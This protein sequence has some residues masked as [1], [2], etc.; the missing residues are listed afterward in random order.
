M[1]IGIITYWFN[2]GQA[3]V[4]RFLRSSLE[5]L[6]YE[7]FVFVR[8]DASAGLTSTQDVWAQSNLHT[9][10][11]FHPKPQEYL[12]WSEDHE[13]D[14]VF[15]FQNYSFTDIAELKNNGITTIGCFMRENIGSNHVADINKAYSLVY[16]VNPS[17]LVRMTE[18]GVKNV[19]PLKWMVHPSLIHEPKPLKPTDVPTFFYPGG[20]SS[21]RKAYSEVVE[22]FVGLETESRLIVKTI[23]SPR[24]PRMLGTSK[25]ITII[26]KELSTEEY[27]NLLGTVDVMIGIARWEGLGL[28]L[29]EAIGRGIPILGTDV[30]P[31]N[32]VVGHHVTGALVDCIPRGKTSSDLPA[33]QHSVSKIT[34]AMEYV[35]QNHENL[36]RNQVA[37]RNKLN[38]DNFERE[39]SNLLSLV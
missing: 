2:R 8:P 12:K 19:H 20:Y 6:G 1:K 29:Y 32:E 37:H 16:A 31:I 9:G 5:N 39:L 14:A 30:N 23:K 17:D 38:W 35:L 21:A 3:T 34:S 11:G 27:S 10:S 36:Q 25:G 24:W 22:A 18:M 7:V 15:L 13:L 26:N 4:G 33:C 28:H